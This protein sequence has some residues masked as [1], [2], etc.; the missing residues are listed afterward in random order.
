MH[1]YSYFI[2]WNQ[3]TLFWEQ[4]IPDPVN[5]GRKSR[6]TEYVPTCREKIG[7][8]KTGAEEELIHCSRSFGREPVWWTGNNNASSL[9]AMGS[10][11]SCYIKAKFPN[12]DKQRSTETSKRR[13][14]HKGLLFWRWTDVL[15][16]TV[17]F[18][19]RLLSAKKYWIIGWT[20]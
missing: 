15:V 6:E 8:N 10:Y 2:N 11:L 3:L 14:T 4:R 9:I 16:T 5:K 13:S 12:F 19:I 17:F 1:R 7:E 18:V 20:K